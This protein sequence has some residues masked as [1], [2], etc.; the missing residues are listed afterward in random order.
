MNTTKLILLTSAVILS[1]SFLILIILLINRKFRSQRK[2]DA[3]DNS[4]Y[5]IHF[6]FQFISGVLIT[7]KVLFLLN[8]TVDMLNKTSDKVWVEC[9]RP[10]SILIGLGLAWFIFWY[11]FVAVLSIL[12]TGKRDLN[13]ELESNHKSYA[14]ERGVLLMG[15]IF[16]LQPVLEL[17]LRNFIPSMEI[18][19]IY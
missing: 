17:I 18:P 16:C 12:A 6:A 9:I 5:S 14:I 2:N 19:F 13:K 10:G 7:S 15:F 4:A 1:L 3:P 8:E 11:F